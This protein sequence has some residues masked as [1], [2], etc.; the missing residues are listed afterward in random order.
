[1]PIP[2]VPGAPSAPSNATGTSPATS[3]VPAAAVNL[4]NIPSVHHVPGVTAAAAVVTD[5]S[6]APGAATTQAGQGEAQPPTPSNA[7]M[8]AE[9]QTPM[10]DDLAVDPSL[11]DAEGDEEHAAKRPRLDDSHDGSLE[12]EAVLNALTAHNHPTPVEDHYTGE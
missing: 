11:E 5:G 3:N 6:G 2:V 12:D 1:M 7:S 8:S 4:Q 9:I 10:A